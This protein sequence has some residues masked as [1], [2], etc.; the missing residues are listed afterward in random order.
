MRKDNKNNLQITLILSIII[1]VSNFTQIPNLIGNSLLKIVQIF[2]WILLFIVLLYK[3]NKLLNIN[4]KLLLLLLYIFDIV[5]ITLTIFTS[6]IYIYSNFIYPVHLS[7]FILIIG[8]FIGQVICE[9]DLRIILNCF[10]ISSF[11][12]A[13]YIY[14]DYFLG[15]DWQNSLAYVYGSKNSISHII[16]TNII[17]LFCFEKIGINK[18]IKYSILIFF[19]IFLLML[20]SRASLIGLISSFIL[21]ISLRI[22]NKKYKV[23]ATILFLLMIFTI[24]SNEDLYN[25]I[26]NQVFLNNRINSDLNTFS[27]G[28][29]DHYDYFFNN[30]RN[31]IWFGNGGEYLESF[32]LAIYMSYGLIG[33]SLLLLIALTPLY[34]LK[35]KLMN[36][37]DNEFRITVLIIFIIFIINSIFEELTPFGPGVKCYI[38]WLLLGIFLSKSNLKKI[39]G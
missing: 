5:I 4:F 10:F 38:L 7:I 36:R 28:R 14:I 22:T 20:K 1:I 23:L 6:K 2:G 21:L 8:S 15:V 17:L 16:L 32:P 3:Y 29:L 33:G 11:I 25:L 30:F 39:R 12:V 13:I 27:S 34:Y 26:I 9:N 19:I 31:N 35:K 24:Y 18:L 37:N